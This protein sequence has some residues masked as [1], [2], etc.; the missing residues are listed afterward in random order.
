MLA[1]NL[2]PLAA[3]ISSL[4]TTPHLADHRNRYVELTLR[5]KAHYKLMDVQ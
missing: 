5:R 3:R 2:E 1:S 4:H